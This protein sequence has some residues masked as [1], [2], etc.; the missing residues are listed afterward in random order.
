MMRKQIALV[1]LLA[2]CENEPFSAPQKLGGKMVAASML[3]D[4]HEGYMLYCYACHGTKGDGNGPSAYSLRPPPRNFTQG[5]FKFAAVASGQLPNDPDF[6]RIV[7]GGLNG[8][9]MLPWDVPEATLT[10]IIQYIKTFSPRWKEEEPGEPIKPSPDPFGEAKKA[11]AIALGEKVYDGL[12]TCWTCHPAY[13]QRAQ[14][15]KATKEMKPNVQ[16]MEFREDLYESVL[17]DSEYLMPG[18][19]DQR[20]NILPPDFMRQPLRSIRAGHELEDFYRVISS[21]IGGTAMPQWK[22]ALPED[23]LWAMA[24]YV[25]SLYEMRDTPA[26]TAMKAQMMTQPK[27]EP[28]APPPEAPPAPTNEKEKK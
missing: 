17:K 28:P 11:E 27:F 4:G 3:N 1:V 12:A 2:A 13:S 9:A 22:G 6:L 26:A 16:T 14:M 25:K 8:T 24:Y 23:K 10:P 18:T 20:L 7:Q 5:K 21:G 15:W 19:T